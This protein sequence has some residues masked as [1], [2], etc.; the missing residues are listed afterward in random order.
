MLGSGGHRQADEGVYSGQP[1]SAA[2]HKHETTV[3]IADV[4]KGMGNV[5]ASVLKLNIPIFILFFAFS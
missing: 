4:S 2:G 5:G 3:L 1:P